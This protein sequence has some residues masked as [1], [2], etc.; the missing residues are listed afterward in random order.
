MLIWHHSFT[1][2][3]A[4]RLIGT[5]LEH[6]AELWL[7]SRAFPW[8]LVTIIA[9]F[10]KNILMVR[11]KDGFDYLVRREPPRPANE[12]QAFKPL[13]AERVLLGQAHARQTV[14]LRVVNGDNFLLKL[15]ALLL[16]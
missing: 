14:L 4:S 3:L 15:L 13:L 16:L 6:L 1:L 7:F 5:F 9:L 12:R 2:C 11:A 8:R 10:K